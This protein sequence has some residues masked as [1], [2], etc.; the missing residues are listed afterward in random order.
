MRTHKA[1][2]H[3]GARKVLPR[4]K[5]VTARVPKKGVSAIETLATAAAFLAGGALALACLVLK[6]VKIIPPG[7]PPP[8]QAAAPGDVVCVQGGRDRARGAP[9]PRKRAALL[10]AKP[11]VI[12]L[13]ED[14]LNAWFAASTHTRA[15]RQINFRIAGG[16]LQVSAP[17]TVRPAASGGITVTAQLRGGFE[18]VAPNPDTGMP[19]VVM[20]APV[21]AYIGSLPVHRIPGGVDALMEKLLS[22][23]TLPGEAI[24]AWRKIE[25]VTVGERELCVTIS[26]AGAG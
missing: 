20:F 3:E 4:K 2:E 12:T 23:Q 19:A 13:T 1:C 15:S 10:S 7:A 25:S 11:G 24:E 14:E 8:A 9:W 18:R 21:E 5:S 22:S 26:K 17:V 16:L 6:P